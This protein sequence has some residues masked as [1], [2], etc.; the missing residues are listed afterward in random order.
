MLGGGW[1]FSFFGGGFGGG[2]ERVGGFSDLFWGVEGFSV[3][4]KGFGG[5]WEGLGGR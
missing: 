4:F 1:G 2:L 3:V 5:F